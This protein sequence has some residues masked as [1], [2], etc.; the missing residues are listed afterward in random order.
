MASNGQTNQ[1]TAMRK[2]ERQF[3][4]AARKLDKETLRK[5]TNNEYLFDNVRPIVIAAASQCAAKAGDTELE[6]MLLMLLTLDSQ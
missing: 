1:V 4:E 2:V 5:I 6:T 3:M